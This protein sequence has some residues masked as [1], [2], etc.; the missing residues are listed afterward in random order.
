MLLLYNYSLKSDYKDY[1]KN[2]LRSLTC[3]A[4]L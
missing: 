2:L 4:L 1:S 3:L